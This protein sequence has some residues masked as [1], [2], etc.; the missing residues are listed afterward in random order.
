LIGAASLCGAVDYWNRD[1][2]EFGIDLPDAGIAD[3]WSE[4]N[5]A[6]VRACCQGWAKLPLTAYL[7][8]TDEYRTE[9]MR[10]HPEPLEPFLAAIQKA[11]GADHG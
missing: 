9:M 1:Q 6:A 2:W 11:D 10:A 7:E 8:L 3:L 5:Q 4:A